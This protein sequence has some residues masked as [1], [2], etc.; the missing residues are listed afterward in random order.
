MLYVIGVVYLWFTTYVTIIRNCIKSYSKFN[1]QLVG[2]EKLKYRQILYTKVQYISLLH[3]YITHLFIYHCSNLCSSSCHQGTQLRIDTINE[4]LS[5]IKALGSQAVSSL[6]DTVAALP[7]FS[8]AI[9]SACGQFAWTTVCYSVQWM[10]LNFKPLKCVQSALWHANRTNYLR[11][12]SP[13]Q[14]HLAAFDVVVI[15]ATA[16]HTGLFRT[17]LEQK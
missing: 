14:C 9:F 6:G 13:I 17:K 16:V 11:I 8:L 5:G 15:G 2:E 4:I 3:L 7:R 12:I 10:S 1:L